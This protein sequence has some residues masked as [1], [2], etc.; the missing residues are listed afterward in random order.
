MHLSRD[1]SG[2]FDSAEVAA[3]DA[4]VPVLAVDT[5]QV[6]FATGYAVLAAAAVA[7]GRRHPRGGGRRRPGP[8][9]RRPRRCSTSTRWSTSAAAAGSAPRPRCWAA[10]WRSSRCCTIDRRQ[11]RLA[12]E[13]AH[14]LAGAR[15]AGGPRRRGRRGR[16]RSRSPSP[17]W[18][19][20]TAPSSWPRSSPSGWSWPRRCGSRRA[21][22][23]ARRARRAGHGLGLRGAGARLIHAV[24]HR[25]PAG[26]VGAGRRALP[27]V[28]A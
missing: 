4:S 18:P 13:G 23:G 1:M 20:P 7:R 12:G 24:V 16:A 26:P 6:G 15:P 9:P 17:T 19:A 3:R 28:A 10:R 14:R 2:T 11:G 8:A 21:R 5:R 25:R 27:S 22:R